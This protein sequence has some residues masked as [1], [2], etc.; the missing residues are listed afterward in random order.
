[1][2]DDAIAEVAAG[3]PL[4]DQLVVHTAGSVPMEVFAGKARNYGVMYPLQSFSK[5][6]PPNFREIPVFLEANSPDSLQ[7]LQSVAG[8]ISDATYSLSSDQR[9]LLHLA[10]VF[11]SN[12]VNSLYALAGGIL[13]EAG[14]DFHV[15]SPLVLET[16]RKAVASRRPETVQTG[17]AV[18]NDRSVMQRHTEWLSAHPEWLQI[19]GQMSDY[20]QR[21]PHE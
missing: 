10:A 13:R 5:D 18:R 7:T 11:G 6:Y 9:L 21:M 12:F 2:S 17:P 8:K 19:Y 14:L 1:V 20:I 3:L 4:K 15:L 16:A